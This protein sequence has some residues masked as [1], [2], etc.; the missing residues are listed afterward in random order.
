MPVF[1]RSH[2]I[3]PEDPRQVQPPLS[4]AFDE[5]SCPGSRV[6]FKSKASSSLN[7]AKNV[8]LLAQLTEKQ[9]IEEI[10]LENEHRLLKAR[11]EVQ[12]ARMNFELLEQDEVCDPV[13][14]DVVNQSEKI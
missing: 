6:S 5:V 10:R 12:M 8:L 13:R 2:I 14:A 7:S 4:H 11:N 3:E 9:L 1:N